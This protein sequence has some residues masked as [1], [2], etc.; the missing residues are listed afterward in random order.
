M[1]DTIYEEENRTNKKIDM[2]KL[3]NKTI[4]IIIIAMI[5]LIVV[6]LLL[7][8]T[9]KE[10]CT[11]EIDNPIVMYMDE[12]LDIPVKIKSST[13]DT[14]EIMT[15]ATPSTDEIITIEESDF[16]GSKGS[17]LIVPQQ[18]G[19]EELDIISSIGVDKY[20]KTL[21]TKQT[22]VIV[23]SKF[24]EN[25]LTEKNILLRPNETSELK[26]NFENDSCFKYIT[27][28]S[29]DEQIATITDDGTITGIAPGKTRIIISNG[30][31]PIYVTVNID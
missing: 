3:S 5:A 23:C 4:L 25:L 27:Y 26:L 28:E 18:T 20:S 24:D 12:P 16:T 11:I 1:E 13:T 9:K 17:F 14:N 19:E 6:V 2:S 10:T 21:N 15:F 8:D 30:T 31:E 22:K 7:K 29:E